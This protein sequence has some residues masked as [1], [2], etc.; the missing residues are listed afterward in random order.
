[1]TAATK[2]ISGNAILHL[3]DLIGDCDN[4][5][6]LLQQSGELETGLLIRQEKH[7]KNQFCKQLNDLLEKDKLK[8]RVIEI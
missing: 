7:L 8:I 4:N 2:H 5:L 6:T 3:L 1:M